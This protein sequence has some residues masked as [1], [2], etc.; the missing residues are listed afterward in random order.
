MLTVCRIAAWLLG[1]TIVVLSLVPPAFRPE[2]DLPH[3]LEHTVI[4]AATGLAFGLG[5]GLRNGLVMIALLVFTGT[6]ELAQ[7][8][9]PGRHARL[10]DFTV[11]AAAVCF[12]LLAAWFVPMRRPEAGFPYQP[13]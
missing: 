10:S 6:I 12:G 4:F 8:M 7:L 3:H 2:T 5:Y 1:A 13:K 9:V 11:D